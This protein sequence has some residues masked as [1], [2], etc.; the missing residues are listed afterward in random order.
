MKLDENLKK[1]E[2][3]ALELEN[4]DISIDEGLKLYE[5][6]VLF[7]KECLAELNEIKGKVNVIKKELDVFKEESLD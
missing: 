5:Q 6:G 4:P 1:I 3:V 7:A 2:E